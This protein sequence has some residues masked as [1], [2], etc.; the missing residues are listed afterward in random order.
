MVHRRISIQFRREAADVGDPL[1]GQASWSPYV[2]FL[3]YKVVSALTVRKSIY[4]NCPETNGSIS[5][6]KFRHQ[7]RNQ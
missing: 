7:Y 5:E 6:G 3:Q 1:I 2:N 4:H